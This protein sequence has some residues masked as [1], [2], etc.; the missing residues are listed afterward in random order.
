MPLKVR[1]DLSICILLYHTISKRIELGSCTKY[2]FEDNFK[3]FPTAVTMNR[4]EQN[5]PQF[6]EELN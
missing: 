2:Q 1:L 5:R 6:F 4:I 3:G